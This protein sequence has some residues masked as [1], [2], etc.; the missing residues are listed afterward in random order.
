[1]KRPPVSGAD[2][3]VF[4][5][6]IVALILYVLYRVLDSLLGIVAWAVLVMKGHQS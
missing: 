3:A 4:C 5:L 6:A 2:V 1:M